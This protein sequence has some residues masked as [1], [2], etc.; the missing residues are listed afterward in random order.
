MKAQT[1]NSVQPQL[2]L[3]FVVIPEE[4]GPTYILCAHNIV[5]TLNFYITMLVMMLS[6]LYTKINSEIRT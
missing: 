1:E 3:G 5:Y 4:M 6:C 2:N